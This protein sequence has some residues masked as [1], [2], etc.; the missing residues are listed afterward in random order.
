MCELKHS[1]SYRIQYN[2][3]VQIIHFFLEMT[4]HL[5]KV[6]VIYIKDSFFSYINIPL[7][8]LIKMENNQPC[9]IQAQQ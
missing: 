4:I 5:P 9:I 1:W 6:P 7:F 2:Y 8:L 3:Y